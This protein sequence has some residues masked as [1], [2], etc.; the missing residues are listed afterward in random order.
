[1]FEF[2]FTD[3]RRGSRSSELESYMESILGPR[4]KYFNEIDYKIKKIVKEPIDN[5][6]EAERHID[7]IETIRRTEA[8]KDALIKLADYRRKQHTDAAMEH[9]NSA[10]DAY[11]KIKELERKMAAEVAAMYLELN[12]AGYHI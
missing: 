11:S 3:G 6:R 1:M 2:A 12:S 5:T 9:F 7:L 10:F 4:K 8:T